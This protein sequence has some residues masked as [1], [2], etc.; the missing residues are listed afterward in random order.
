MSRSVVVRWMISLLAFGLLL[1]AA[2]GSWA[3]T[4]KIATIVPDG[5]SWLTE[6]RK[7]GEEIKEKPMGA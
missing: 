6:M 1:G 3:R 7:A 2:P 5:S 4:V